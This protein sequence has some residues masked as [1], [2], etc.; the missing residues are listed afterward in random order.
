MEVFVFLK[1]VNGCEFFLFEFVSVKFIVI[2]LI[3]LKFGFGVIFDLI[4]LF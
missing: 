2:V 4:K 1:I 3:I